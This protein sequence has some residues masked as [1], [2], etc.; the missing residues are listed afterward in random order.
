MPREVWLVSAGHSASRDTHFPAA[1]A[2][3]DRR[4]SDTARYTGILSTQKPT[5]QSIE[6][7]TLCR[8]ICHCST[9]CCTIRL[10]SGT[11]LPP[12]PH[13]ITP[14]LVFRLG[15]FINLKS[16]SQS[17]ADRTRKP[18]HHWRHPTHVS[19]CLLQRR[20]HEHQLSHRGRPPSTLR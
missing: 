13:A 10:H 17:S 1:P 6:V 14:P 7:H 4:D 9:S 19:V 5:H 3:D 2:A 16:P 20:F 11:S 8:N 18:D 15:S 12:A